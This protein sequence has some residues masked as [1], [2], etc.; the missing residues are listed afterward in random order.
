M[1]RVLKGPWQRRQSKYQLWHQLWNDLPVLPS[2]DMERLIAELAVE[3]RG[4]QS[5]LGMKP[6][7]DQAQWFLGFVG[8]AGLEWPPLEPVDFR[9]VF[10]ALKAKKTQLMA[11]AR[12]GDAVS[13][14]Q[15]RKLWAIVHDSRYPHVD[16]DLLYHL[17]A[18]D[19]P[20]ARRRGG[21]GKWRPS[22][23]SLT[24]REAG[25]LIDNLLHPG[26]APQR[27]RA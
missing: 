12:R 22:M 24:G 20:K 17:I 8:Q 1:A 5:H 19:F 3:L 14:A 25:Q 10:Q 9:A 18:Q 2:P 16:K 27:R 26:R 21:D 11:K 23:S 13:D 6:V 7:H 15:R 4:L